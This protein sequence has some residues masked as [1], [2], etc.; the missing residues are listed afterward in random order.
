MGGGIGKWQGQKQT[1]E[2]HGLLQQMLSEEVYG[3]VGD[4]L[5]LY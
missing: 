3:R 4:G 1:K 2:A 5:S